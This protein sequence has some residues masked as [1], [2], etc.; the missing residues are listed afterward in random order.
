MAQT[1]IYC[2][3]TTVTIRMHF[4]I[5]IKTFFISN[6]YTYSVDWVELITVFNMFNRNRSLYVPVNTC[7]YGPKF[8]DECHMLNYNWI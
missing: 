7:H 5:S 6:L 3:V 2:I 8:S 4:Y 1:Y